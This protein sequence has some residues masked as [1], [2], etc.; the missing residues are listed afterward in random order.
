MCTCADCDRPATSLGN[1]S[2][3]ISTQLWGAKS[4]GFPALLRADVCV[5]RVAVPAGI[6]GGVLSLGECARETSADCGTALR[7][8][9]HAGPIGSSCCL[10]GPCI[11]DNT[12]A[13][14]GA[15]R[16]CGIQGLRATTL[17]SSTYR[18]S[19]CTW[20]YQGFLMPRR[21]HHLYS[22]CAT[23]RSLCQPAGGWSCLT[24]PVRPPCTS[25]AEPFQKRQAL[26]ACRQ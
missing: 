12:R 21:Q 17:S 13:A 4:S 16:L 6:T 3:S 25:A 5:T 23:S 2:R 11:T 10:K 26:C 22:S 1:A 9:S 7:C 20:F 19:A 14:G 8:M 24:A 18:S 15:S